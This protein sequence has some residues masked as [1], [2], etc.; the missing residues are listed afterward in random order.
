[1]VI[2]SFKENEVLT[3]ALW[4]SQAE[5]EVNSSSEI[6]KIFNKL[7]ASLPKRSD[8][9][10]IA[11]NIDDFLTSNNIKLGVYKK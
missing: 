10:I 1:M 3:L 8:K 5:V 9:N 4:L 2:I 11:L 6:I 7:K